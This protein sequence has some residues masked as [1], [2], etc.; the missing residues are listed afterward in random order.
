MTLAITAITGV[1]CTKTL[2]AIALPSSRMI[3]FGTLGENLI[4]YH[5]H[6]L[7]HLGIVGNPKAS[8]QLVKN[9]RPYRKVR[10]RS[11]AAWTRQCPA[12]ALAIGVQDFSPI[13]PMF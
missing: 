1:D 2:L 12:V 5:L 8:P 11:V 10:R 7:Q 3:L 4:L 9:L 13:K 6:Q